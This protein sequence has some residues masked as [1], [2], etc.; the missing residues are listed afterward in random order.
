MENHWAKEMIEALTAQGIIQGY[1]DGTFRPNEP[2]SRMHV[3]ALLTRAFSFEPVRLASD[4]TDV[5]PAHPYY[6]AIKVLQQA[7][8][9]DGVN[10]AF[11]PTEK[12]TRAQ[13]AKIL[14]GVLGL[15]P[16]GTTS[17]IDVD[18]AHWSAGYIAVL[19]REGIA[20]GDNG[21]FRPNESVTRAQFV[22]FL[23]RAYMASN[24]VVLL[25]DELIE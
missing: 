23:Y 16:E 21:E 5:S 22:A 6:D 12:M 25:E 10:G 8:I 1:E 18:S 19:E 24:Q 14:V 2:V 20:L 4:F 17:F 3:A 13:L 15:T 11:L 9:V 7:R